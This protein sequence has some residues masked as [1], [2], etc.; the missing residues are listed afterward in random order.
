[1]KVGIRLHEKKIIFIQP[2]RENMKYF[3]C[4]VLLVAVLVTAGCISENKNVVVTPTATV[5]RTTDLPVSV[6]PTLTEKPIQ[7]DTDTIKFLDAVENCY[8]HTPVINDTKTYL[9]FTICMQ[10]TPI[11]ITYCAKQFR[12]EI[13]E[14]ATKDDDTTSGYQRSTYNMQVARV[15]F[16]D[17]L[18]RTGTQY[19]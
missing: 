4:I 19:F 7:D 15:R 14:Y 9:E 11:P 3:L 6:V 5:T 10:H 17:C 1:M 12:S 2:I 8:N 18:K 16:S 13:L